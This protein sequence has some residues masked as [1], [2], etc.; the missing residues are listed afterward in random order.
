M[1]LN[2]IEPIDDIPR[3]LRQIGALD[4]GNA[5]DSKAVFVCDDEMFVSLRTLARTTPKLVKSPK[6]ENET[7]MNC[8]KTLYAK[9]PVS[10]SNVTLK[11]LKK[12][13]RKAMKTTKQNRASSDAEDDI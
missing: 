9:R 3:C 13:T 5:M 8:T 1:Y 7:R 10:S 4:R 6:P 2:F 11:F 12:F